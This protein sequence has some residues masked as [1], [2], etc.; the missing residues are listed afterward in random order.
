[1]TARVTLHWNVKLNCC[2]P[3]YSKAPETSRQEKT[4][5]LPAER[6]LPVTGP[7]RGFG[8]ACFQPPW[9]RHTNPTPPHGGTLNLVASQQMC[10]TMR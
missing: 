2:G 8:A 9:Q 6:S 7:G 3:G 4:K 10:K 1:M 5:A